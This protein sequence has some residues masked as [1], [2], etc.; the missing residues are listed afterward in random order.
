MISD[1]LGVGREKAVT[2]ANLARTTG[3]SERE[4]RQRVSDERARGEVILSTTEITGGYYL[5]S[6]R[7]E[8]EQFINAMTKRGRSA[9]RALKS[10]K[11]LLKEWDT[12]DRV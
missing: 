2:L 11:K 10:A 6:S 8:I 4:V 3:L 9:F 5:P 1:Y 7:A 12:D